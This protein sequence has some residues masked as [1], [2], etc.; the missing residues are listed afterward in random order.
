MKKFMLGM[1]L[2]L[3]IT[4]NANTDIGT[5]KEGSGKILQGDQFT[6]VKKY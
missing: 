1:A 4:L 6:V 5:V 2:G 3:G